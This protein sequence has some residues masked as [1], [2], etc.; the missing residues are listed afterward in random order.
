[1]KASALKKKILWSIAGTVVSALVPVVIAKVR[2]LV[3][4]KKEFKKKDENLN[5]ALVASMDCSDPVAKY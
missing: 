3:L 5:K 2:S 4:E 1:M